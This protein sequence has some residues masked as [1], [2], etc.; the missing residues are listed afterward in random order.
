MAAD[1]VEFLNSSPTAFHAVDEAKKRLRS[2]GY[3]QVSE[4]EDW[5]LEAGKKYF[6]T[7]NHSTIVAFA[8]G[9]RYVAGNGFH[10]IGAHTDSPCLK[11]KPVSKK[12]G[13][14]EVGLQTYGGG[15]WHTWFDRDL[16]VAGRMIIREGKDSGVLV[17][18]SVG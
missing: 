16:T 18:T 2:A 6:F 7:R 13:Y 4:R 14:L 17:F 1:L 10:I 8:I 3:E 11:L 15:L 12:G 5:S 9:K